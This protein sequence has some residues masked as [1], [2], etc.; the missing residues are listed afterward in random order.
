MMLVKAH[1]NDWTEGPACWELYEA[2][3]DLRYLSRDQV[4]DVPVGDYDFSEDTRFPYSNI[5]HVTTL[6]KT[7]AVGN[8]QPNYHLRWVLWRDADGQLHKLITDAPVYILN[9]R[10]DTIEALR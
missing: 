10:G 5:T 4:I 1:S 9:D 6:H 7:D 2:H 3:S 8:K